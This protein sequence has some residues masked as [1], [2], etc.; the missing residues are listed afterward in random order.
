VGFSPIFVRFILK[1]AQYIPAPQESVIGVVSQR[2]GEGYRV[3]VGSAHS[4][5]LDGLAFEGATKRN[6][7]NLKVNHLLSVGVL[8]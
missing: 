2:Q 1:G 3:D 4:A 8:V 7:P 5:T 6:K